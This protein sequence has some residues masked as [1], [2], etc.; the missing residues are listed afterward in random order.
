LLR[1]VQPQEE[2]RDLKG[3]LAQLGQLLVEPLAPILPEVARLYVQVPR[4][5]SALPLSALPFADGRPLC[6][7]G[8]VIVVDELPALGGAPAPAAAAAPAGPQQGAALEPL[9]LL[10]APLLR[11]PL[12]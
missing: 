11:D 3:D 4:D 10:G 8:A 7:R 1:L 9:L 5:L 6:S 12:P 2:A